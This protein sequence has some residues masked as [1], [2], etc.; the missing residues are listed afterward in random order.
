MVNLEKTGYN[1][2]LLSSAVY[3]TENG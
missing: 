2:L 1:N 3:K